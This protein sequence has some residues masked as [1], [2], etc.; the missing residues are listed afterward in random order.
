MYSDHIVKPS[1]S[2]AMVSLS[3]FLYSHYFVWEKFQSISNCFMG[4]SNSDFML[5]C[6]L[7]IDFDGFCNIE[8]EIS[9]SF[10]SFCL[11]SLVLRLTS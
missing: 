7:K 11:D 10:C 6:Q 2:L 5:L 9:S 3:D 4:F 8:S 1:Q